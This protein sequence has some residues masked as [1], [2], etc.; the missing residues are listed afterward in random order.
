MEFELDRFD[1]LKERQEQRGRTGFVVQYKY[2]E[3]LALLNDEERS[4]FLVA[5]YEYDLTGEIPKVS[6]NVKAV[7][8]TLK[9]DIDKTREVWERNSKNAKARQNKSGGSAQADGG[10]KNGDAQ[11][12]SAEKEDSSFAPPTLKEVEEYSKSNNLT[13]AAADFLDYYRSNGWMVGKNKMNDWKAAAQRWSRRSF[14]IPAAKGQ[15]REKAGFL[16]REFD[17]KKEK[18]RRVM[19]MFEEGK[20]IDERRKAD[21]G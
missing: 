18:E 16:Q 15:K 14:E 17:E 6:R 19:L 10:L 7:L 4:E 20:R 2:L 12:K 5:L 3:V 21:G 11:E 1:E 8:K 13:L 9:Y